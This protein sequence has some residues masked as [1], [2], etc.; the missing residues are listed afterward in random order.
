MQYF[1]Y[2]ACIS[3][4]YDI[5]KDKAKVLDFC[6]FIKEN[7]SSLVPIPELVWEGCNFQKLV[8]FSESKSFLEQFKEEIEKGSFGVS[9]GIE[10]IIQIES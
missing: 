5:H 4:N 10:K 3:F 2:E 7:Y 8:Y 6:E 1:G 9:V